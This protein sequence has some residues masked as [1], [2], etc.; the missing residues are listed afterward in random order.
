METQL[1]QAVRGTITDEMRSVARDEGVDDTL[2][3][4][5][6][7]AGRLIIPANANHRN[8]KPVGIGA[9]LRCKVIANIGNSPLTSDLESEIVKLSAAVECGADAV[10]DLSTGPR[11]EGIRRSIIEASTVP[12]GTVPIYEAAEGVEEI[13]D[14]TASALFDVI[15]RHAEQGVDFV[16]VH[17]GLLRSHVPLALARTTGIVS[18]G[19]ALTARWMQRNAKENP[20]YEEFDRLL[21]ICR[22]HDVSL[23]LGDG[24]R[25]GSIADASDAAQFAELEVLGELARRSRDA[26][27]QVMIEG[28]GHIPLNEIEMNVKKQ[29][30]LCDGTPFY[31]LG[32]LVTDIGAGHD[33]RTSA[34]GG[35]VAGAA[36]VAMLCYVTP[37]EHLGLPNTDEVRAGVIAHRIAAHAADVA[38]GRPMAR[39]RDRDL[40]EARYAL[41]WETQFELLLDPIGARA[42]WERGR[43]DACKTGEDACSMCGP[44]FCAMR[45]SKNIHNS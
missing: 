43:D 21:A 25:P 44:K 19:G 4:G 16:T 38:R 29:I 22:K 42:I 1:T 31:V 11:I 26:G 10:M 13:E 40:S 37:A 45:I 24:L 17:C 6:I 7:A 15:E 14:L 36:G 27:V 30:E 41:D 35:A 9:A 33:H 34:I 39:K 23:S 2:V 18:R 32:P 5:E 3:Q 28:P 8:L 20:L 12:V